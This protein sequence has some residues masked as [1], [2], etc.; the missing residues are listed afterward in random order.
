MRLLTLDGLPEAEASERLRVA[1]RSPRGARRVPPGPQRVPRGVEETCDLG[2]SGTPVGQPSLGTVGSGTGRWPSRVDQR[3]QRPWQ[4]SPATCDPT[5]P[6]GRG[7]G[8]EAAGLG[9][10]AVGPATELRGTPDADADAAVPDR[11]RLPGGPRGCLCLPWA[12]E[13]A[14]VTGRHRPVLGCGHAEG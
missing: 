2:P 5:G 9:Q 10:T 4:L 7:H 14:G 8:C 1:A 12:W 11:G 13:A 3:K 6:G